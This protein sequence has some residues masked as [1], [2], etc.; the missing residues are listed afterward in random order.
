MVENVTQIKSGIAITVGVSV[1]TQKNI[2]HPKKIMFGT[3]LHVVVKMI[4]I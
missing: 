3:L 1:K 4:N 2:M